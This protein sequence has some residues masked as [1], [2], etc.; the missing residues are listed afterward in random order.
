MATSKNND[1]SAAAQL[2]QGKKTIVTSEPPQIKPVEPVAVPAVKKAPAAK[3][4]EAEKAAAIDVADKTE[5]SYMSIGFNDHLFKYLK[6]IST[7]DG[8]TVTKYLNKLV[9]TDY[10]KRRGEINNIV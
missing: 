5:K 7:A 6:F 1:Y 2:L 4:V 3:P 9:E 10:Q 8:T